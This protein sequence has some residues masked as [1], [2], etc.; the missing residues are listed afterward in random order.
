[1]SS[2]DLL[3]NAGVSAAGGPHA[4]YTNSAR[5]LRG[6]GGVPMGVALTAYKGWFHSL[7]SGCRLAAC[8]L[9]VGPCV[10]RCKRRHVQCRQAAIMVQGVPGGASW[11]Q[12]VIAG[13]PDGRGRTTVRQHIYMGGGSMPALSTD[14][15]YVPPVR[16]CPHV[17]QRRLLRPCAGVCDAMHVHAHNHAHN[18]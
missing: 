5:F 1:M 13:A 18:E 17:C 10:E 7:T 16:A 6:P 3:F 15:Q 4:N 14:P 2:G 12:V 11:A 8:S 9:C